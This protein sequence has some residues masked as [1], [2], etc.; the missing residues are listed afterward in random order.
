LNTCLKNTQNPATPFDYYTTCLAS[1]TT[2]YLIPITAYKCTFEDG[3]VISN[4]QTQLPSTGGTTT[5]LNLVKSVTY[6]LRY[7][8]TV[9][10]VIEAAIEAVFFNYASYATSSVNVKQTFRIV[11]IP[12]SV[13]IADYDTLSTTVLSGNPGYL[14][15]KPIQAGVKQ[16]SSISYINYITRLTFIKI[17]LIYMYLF[18]SVYLTYPKAGSDGTCPTDDSTRLNVNFG[19]NTL[20]EC[21]Y[22]YA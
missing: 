4:C 11:Y 3:T 20:S 22:S 18:S 7:D 19:I 2:T 8:S 12:S 21:F 17:K 5:C 9:G 10:G 14:V 13:Q 16:T 15:G 1:T 6:I